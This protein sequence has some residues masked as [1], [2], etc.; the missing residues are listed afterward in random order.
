MKRLFTH[1]T[2][3]IA[4]LYRIGKKNMNNLV[5]IE[6]D[7][8]FSAERNGGVLRPV[9]HHRILLLITALLSTG[10][11]FFAKTAFFLIPKAKNGQISPNF[12]VSPKK[13]EKKDEFRKEETLFH[14]LKNQI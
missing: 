3:S 5:P 8:C 11:R 1:P 4:R 2:D 9:I 12:C 14:D 7:P 6:P 13:N 10:G